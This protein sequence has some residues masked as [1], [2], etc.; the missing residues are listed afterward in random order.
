M[1][2]KRCCNPLLRRIFKAALCTALVAGFAGRPHAALGQ[3]ERAPIRNPEFTFRSYVCTYK[4]FKERQIVMQQYD[5][6][7]GAAVLATIIKY[8]WGDETDELYFLEMLPRLK[9]SEKELK[10]R[11]E[12]GLTLTDLRNLAN[13]AGYHATMAKVKFEEVSQ[14]KVPVVVGITVKKHEHF[15]VFRGAD[16]RYV[17]LADPIR[18]NIRTPICDFVEQWQKNA[19]LI[20]AKPNTEV[21]AV[22]PMGIREDE[23]YRGVLNDQTVRRNALVP[24]IPLPG[25]L[26]P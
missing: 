5:Y 10:D 17:Y 14:G 3:C 21:K 22:N 16:D 11:I 18:G 13:M 12:N 1:I 20:I 7:C 26:A 4:E 9:L 8:Y 23:Y 15:A 2:D 19:I 6:S 24:P 25:P